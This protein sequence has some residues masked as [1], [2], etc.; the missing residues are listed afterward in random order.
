MEVKCIKDLEV[1]GRLFTITFIKNKT[2]KRS[3]K[4]LKYLIHLGCFTVFYSD[5]SD[6]FKII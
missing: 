3:L 1:E 6:Y 5:Y 2:Y 4:G